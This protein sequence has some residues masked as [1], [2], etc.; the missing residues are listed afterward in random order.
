VPSK[1]NT[2]PLSTAKL[3]AKFAIGRCQRI[4]GKALG[5]LEEGLGEVL[6]GT[7]GFWKLN[8]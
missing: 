5:G 3:F 7:L 8:T 4:F 6:G 1:T 2:F